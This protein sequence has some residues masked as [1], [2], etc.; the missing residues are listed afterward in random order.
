MWEWLGQ[1]DISD[2]LEQA[3][4]QN[5]REGKVRTYDMGGTNSTTD[6]ANDIANIFKKL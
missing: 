4:A 5:V 6:V 1:S 2:K 3:I